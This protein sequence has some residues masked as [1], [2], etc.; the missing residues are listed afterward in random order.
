MTDVTSFKVTGDWRHIVDDGMVDVDALPDEAL[1]TGHVLFEPVGPQV[2]VAGVPSTAYTLGPVTG[3][4]AAGEL[5]DLQGREGVWL[6]GRIGEYTVRWRATTVLRFGGD[7][8]AYPTVEFDLAS[9]VRLTGLIQNTGPGLPPIVVDP[10]IEELALRLTEAAAAAKAAKESET[11]ARGSQ[12]AAAGSATAA[13]SSAKAAKTSETNAKESEAAAAGS[14]SAA[15]GSATAADTS[16]KA[17]KTSETNAGASA[18]TASTRAS[19]ASASAA[20]AK[21]SETAAAGSA[22]SASTKAGEAADAAGRAVTAVNGFG[23][24]ATATTGA[25]G[26]QAAVTVS[27]TAPKYSLQFQVPRGDTGASDWSAITG[28]PS[29][30]TPAPHTHTSAQITDAAYYASAGSV[31]ARDNNA[32]AQIANPVTGMD[33]MNWQTAEARY[34]PTQHTHTPASLGAVAAAGSAATLWCGTQA[35]YDA[36]ASATKNAAGFIAVI[37]A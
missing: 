1:P 6:A 7:T 3:L 26:S 35:Q 23:V 18:G 5:N 8:I 31:M 28:K 16:A 4:V 9:D 30:F 25:P 36:L 21:I 29:T 22:V 20:A 14:N 15:A 17:A 13:D 10:R 24:T 37:T 2:A 12:S 33:I 32:R 19:E 11:A 34:A 27:G